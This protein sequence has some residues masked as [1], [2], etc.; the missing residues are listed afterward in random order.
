MSKT[1]LKALWD[2]APGDTNEIGF[3]KGDLI[4]LINK[5]N[6]EW[7]EGE[8]NGISGFFPANRVT[9]VEATFT[10]AVKPKPQLATSPSPQSPPTDAA[11]QKPGV[12]PKPSLGPAQAPNIAALTAGV[13]ATQVSRSN[14]ETTPAANIR[15]PKP[16]VTR[17]K[18][19]FANAAMPQQ[20]TALPQMPVVG[21]QTRAQEL[22]KSQKPRGI[23]SPAPV[24]METAEE[25]AARSVSAGTSKSAGPEVQLPASRQ[26]KLDTMSVPM[27]NPNQLKKTSPSNSNENLNQ[28]PSQSGNSTPGTRARPGVSVGTPLSAGTPGDSDQELNV[29]DDFSD[30]ST[31]DLTAPNPTDIK[32]AGFLSKKADASSL[33]S[34]SAW[35]KLYVEL[36]NNHLYFYKDT[37]AKKRV[38]KR[39]KPVAC[40]DIRNGRIDGTGNVDKKKT[41]FCIIVQNRPAI[42]LQA[43]SENDM[44]VWLSAICEVQG[45]KRDEIT[46]DMIATASGRKTETMKKSST[47]THKPKKGSQSSFYSATEDDSN[48]S[49]SERKE[50]AK[51]KLFGFLRQRPTLDALQERGIIPQDLVFGGFLE[52]QCEKENRLVPMIVEKCVQ[53]VELKGLDCQG[54]YRLSGNA[55]TIQ[56]LRYQYNEDVLSVDLANEEWSDINVVTGT[57]KLYFRELQDPLLT[58]E[59][60]DSYV[61]AAKISDADARMK[62]LKAIVMDLPPCNYATLK[63]LIKHLVTVRS[64]KEVNKMDAA[65]LA[66]VFGPTLMRAEIEGMETI[67]N[68]G[69]QNAA[70]ET[71]ILTYDQMFAK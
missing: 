39:D 65:N 21:A 38:D 18:S 71:M 59:R 41:V 36:A 1:Q 12:R 32:W 68:M 40:I 26:R 13:A 16:D 34:L 69:F 35:K 60:Y 22:A 56:K 54:I 10:A 6:A 15:A 9:E 44:L 62:A 20:A 58:F 55:S 48:L 7:W 28:Q 31:A 49:E 47:K 3:K 45:V 27:R 5:S 66:I 29:D 67:L 11:A 30:L 51:T 46:S 53:R 25:S 50:R 37:Q 2:Y 14:L 4:N 19:E 63:F 17:P 64:Y 57:M 42:L 61:Q 23:S 70:I 33:L 52:L 8:I 43:N 24:N